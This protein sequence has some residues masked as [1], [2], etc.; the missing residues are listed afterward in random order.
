MK[1]GVGKDR[2]LMLSEVYL[3]VGL[4]TDAGVFA[5]CMRDAGIEIRLGDG[6]W[7]RWVDGD[8]PVMLKGAKDD[9]DG[10]RESSAA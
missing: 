2:E 8:G 10:L 3:G 9:G 5:V 4:E 6:P 7:Y 1:I